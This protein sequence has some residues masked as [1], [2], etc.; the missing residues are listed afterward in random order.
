MHT[1]NPSLFDSRTFKASMSIGIF[2]YAI[3]SNDNQICEVICG[4]TSLIS[5]D[6]PV[7]PTPVITTN[8]Y[9]MT[10]LFIATSI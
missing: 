3:A 1:Q 7:H 10:L 2:A 8:P 6:R 4:G 9:M 5:A